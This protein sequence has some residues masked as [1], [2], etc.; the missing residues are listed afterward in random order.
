MKE[1][2]RG[3]GKGWEREVEKKIEETEDERAGGGGEGK[4]AL[5][6]IEVDLI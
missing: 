1:E 4:T 2:Q 6:F 3:D 5:S